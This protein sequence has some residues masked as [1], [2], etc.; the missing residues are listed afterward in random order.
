MF[1]SKIS[2]S[3]H[4]ITKGTDALHRANSIP[5]C[6]AKS[7]EIFVRSNFDLFANS[8]KTVSIA[9]YLL[10]SKD[11][12]M[13]ENQTRWKNNERS[14]QYAKCMSLATSTTTTTTEKSRMKKRLWHWI[15]SLWKHFDEKSIGIR[16]KTK[17]F[18][19]LFLHQPLQWDNAS[20]RV[21]E[22]NGNFPWHYVR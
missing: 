19:L 12:T 16:K 4:V 7:K 5:S 2:Q 11:P 21:W 8:V 10:T 15:I 6:L 20:D 22:M 14:Y 13:W 1:G 9:I 18:V 17:H 3:S